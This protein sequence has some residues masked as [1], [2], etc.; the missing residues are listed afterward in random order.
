[1]LI[2]RDQVTAALQV[3]GDAIEGAQ[4]IRVEVRTVEGRRASTSRLS[5]PSSRAMATARRAFAASPRCIGRVEVDVPVGRY[6]RACFG[7]AVAE[8]HGELA[9]PVRGP[10]GTAQWP[11]GDPVPPRN[12]RARAATGPPSPRLMACCSAAS[13]TAISRSAAASRP[14]Y[15]PS[16]SSP[17][18]RSEARR[19]V[20]GRPARLHGRTR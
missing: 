6:Q 3:A 16:S 10:A 20:P 4:T 12:R 5:S 13:R 8:L 18:A 7:V 19:T 9:V 11:A 1:M 17:R 15:R 14:R 2:E